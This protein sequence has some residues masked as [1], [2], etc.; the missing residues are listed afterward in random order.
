MDTIILILS[1]IILFLLACC[2]EPKKESFA[3]FGKT[4]IK[5]QVVGWTGIIKDTNGSD[6]DF[7][8]NKNIIKKDSFNLT[9]NEKK[10]LMRI[11]N[12]IIKQINNDLKLEFHF[13][14]FEHVITQNLE[15]DNRRYIID[16]FIHE[17][18]KYYDKRLIADV[19][20]DTKK[21]S[22]NVTNLTIGNGII[23]KTNDTKALPSYSTKIISDNNFKNNNTI[24]GNEDNNLDYEI[25]KD[26]PISF[27]NKNRNF[28]EWI[29]SKKDTPY[30]KQNWPCRE[31]GN[32]WDFDSIMQSEK[33]NQNCKDIN[34]SHR[35]E[36][37]KPDFYPSFKIIE[38]EG[39]Y[40]WLWGN[41]QNTNKMFS[42]G[43][44]Y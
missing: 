20:L 15:E 17:T 22:V 43:V 6:I 25:L 13:I 9:V 35:D 3:K 28:T 27:I 38:Q 7:N 8:I 4:D 26:K 31:Q 41:S 33:G 34:T 21:N 30:Q 1:I 11:V 16:F 36:I 12:P 44:S 24:I 18:N 37:Q 23:E 2:L 10:E 40:N 29:L 32:K 14:E 5:N 39:A 19:I 42:G